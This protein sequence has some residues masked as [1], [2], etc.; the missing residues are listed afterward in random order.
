MKIHYI[1]SHLYIVLYC[2]YVIPLY[3]T[4]I[5]KPVIYAFSSP[6]IITIIII[7]SIIII[8]V[9]TTSILINI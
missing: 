4:S 6:L 5:F 2:F 3:N 8:S 1:S 7:T 9:I